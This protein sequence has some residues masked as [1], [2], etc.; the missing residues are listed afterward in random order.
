M[1]HPFFYSSAL[2]IYHTFFEKLDLPLH[3]TARP[4]PVILSVVSLFGAWS[5]ECSHVFILIVALNL[6]EYFPSSN[7][8]E[9][10]IVLLPCAFFFLNSSLEME[11]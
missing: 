7:I 3:W 10:L 2:Y 11:N 4:R 1:P 6:Y 9:L 8:P 5:I